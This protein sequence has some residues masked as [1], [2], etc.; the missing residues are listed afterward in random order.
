[1]A[2]IAATG[3]PS[4]GTFL[5]GD[6]TWAT[7]T[8]TSSATSSTQGIVQVPT[9]SGLRVNSG[10]ISVDPTQGEE[11]PAKSVGIAAD[12][13]TDDSAA[14]NAVQNETVHLPD[15]STIL[16]SNL[17]LHSNVRFVCKGCVI[18]HNPADTS[19]Y[20]L[21]LSFLSNVEFSGVTFDGNAVNTGSYSGANAATT[22]VSIT[23]GGSN[24]PPNIKLGFSLSGGSGGLS[25]LGYLQTNSSG[26]VTSLTLTSPGSDNV[27]PTGI[28]L[29]G[30]N[31]PGTSTFTCNGL[32][33][34]ISALSNSTP[35]S[36]P[37]IAKV[38][39]TTNFVLR[40][41]RMINTGAVA[42]NLSLYM[43]GFYF[44]ETSYTLDNLRMDD[45]LV[46]GTQIEDDAGSQDN[47]RRI[48]SSYLLGSTQNAIQLK[49]SA[50]NVEISGGTIKNVTDA[51][52]G[53]GSN[54]NGLSMYGASNLRAHDLYINTVQFSC[55]RV[56]GATAF[57]NH[58][59]H[60]VCMNAGEGAAYTE[61]GAYNNIL[62][63][64]RF[65]N[66]DSGLHG[67]NASSRPNLAKN[68]FDHNIINGCTSY[69]AEME[70]DDFTNN[71]IT[72]CAIGLEV[73]NGSSTGMGMVISGNSFHSTGSGTYSPGM[74][75]G[76]DV[77][78]GVPSSLGNQIGTQ[79]VNNSI[80]NNI[81]IP[82]ISLN[83]PGVLGISNLV[84]CSTT[85]TCVTLFTAPS[86]AVA[87]NQVY[88]IADQW[89][90]GMYQINGGLCQVTVV[91]DTTHFTCGNLNS[92]TWG[93]FVGWPLGGTKAYLVSSSTTTPYAPYYSWPTSVGW[94]PPPATYTVTTSATPTFDFNRGATQTMAV[95]ANTSPVVTSL[96]AGMGVNI[97][98]CN[99]TSNSYTLTWPA[100]V[101]GFNTSIAASAG[102][103][104]QQGISID[105]STLL[106][107]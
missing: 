36:Y 102:C 51:Q 83:N 82:I 76:I 81:A 43:G 85:L 35:T 89:A 26:V 6:G 87:V 39:N 17:T 69:G 41:C 19:H 54:G 42:S 9:T 48:N 10:S 66:V 65:Y 21:N 58:V 98:L 105:G 45:S 96:G 106:R 60:S 74:T 68:Y 50:S 79:I 75:V 56:T 33:V 101:I 15:N 63:F 22:K 24:F 53:N 34:S 95:T 28:S 62:D 103:V 57:N 31:P 32:T 3:S 104:A 2:D 8:G 70:H 59:S 107:E 71:D 84:N 4:N 90:T 38:F 86:F 92:S 88:L 99:S 5:R 44:Y 67:T 20:L 100:N 72:N 55:F 73:G 23:S 40:D 78:K 61:L 77:D 27:V 7:I 49:G 18:K 47:A 64:N 1:M 16:A 37:Y 13:V 30:C 52:Y 91:T 14:L 46:G 80:D 29:V 11:V 94:A 25:P 12:G 97:V 93:T